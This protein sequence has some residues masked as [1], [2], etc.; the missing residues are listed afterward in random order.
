MTP[1]YLIIV[2]IIVVVLFSTIYYLYNSTPKQVKNEPFADSAPSNPITVTNISTQ[3]MA[4]FKPESVRYRMV[5]ASKRI[6]TNG[7]I[8]L[9]KEDTYLDKKK[10]SG[11]DDGIVGVTVKFDTGIIT[12]NRL[13]TYK[14]S[15][16]LNKVIY[17]NLDGTS[18]LDLLLV[19]RFDDTKNKLSTT[20]SPDTINTITLVLDCYLKDTKEII[21]QFRLRGSSLGQLDI[22]DTS[23]YLFIERI[24]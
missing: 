9:L 6:N 7:T 12:L 5:G 17:N 11:T 10:Y 24:A 19:D 15:L 18:D 1:N 3:L 21:P 13:H 14:V 16:I 20:V 8:F 23:V 4:S 2:L 22:I